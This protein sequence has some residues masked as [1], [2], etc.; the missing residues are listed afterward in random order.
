M[1]LELQTKS[2]WLKKSSNQLSMALGSQA[3]K[4]SPLPD[5]LHP[6]KL[7]EAQFQRIFLAKAKSQF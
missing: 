7:L 6:T 2:G 1:D 5:T 4:N 3:E